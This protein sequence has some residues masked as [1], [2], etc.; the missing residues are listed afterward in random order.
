MGPDLRSS[1]ARCGR[2]TVGQWGVLGVALIAG[3]AVALSDPTVATWLDDES[4]LWSDAIN[5]STPIAPNNAMDQTY[6]AEIAISGHPFTITLDDDFVISELLFSS[7][8]A[9]INAGSR[10]LGVLGTSTLG[11]G[12]LRGGPGGAFRFATGVAEHGAGRN[13]FDTTFNGTNIADVGTLEV[14]G[15]S[16]FANARISGVASVQLG[17]N[18]RLE[19]TEIIGLGDSMT[20]VTTAANASLTAI[21][22][23]FS[24]ALVMID[25]T[26]QFNG[27][28]VADIDDTCVGVGR[29]V[30]DLG[31]SIGPTLTGNGEFIVS[32]GA[33]LNIAG[34]AARTMSGVGP[35]TQRVVVEEGGSFVQRDGGAFTL[36]SVD[37][38]N[39]GTVRVAQGLLSTDGVDTPGDRLT[40][41]QWQV[42]ANSELR[43]VGADI[44]ELAA[45]VSLE[46]PAAKFDA[47]NGLERIVTDG[48][49]ALGAQRNF[50]TAG[51]FD[52][53]AG[54]ALSVAE[55]AT[56]NATG[57]LANL[58]NG[59]L[60]GGSFDLGGTLQAAN[61]AGIQRVQTDLTLRGTGKIDNGLGGDAIASMTSIGEIGRVS[62]L[63][64]RD[65]LGLTSLT[66]EGELRVGAG[67][68]TGSREGITPGSTIEVL[69]DYIQAEG[70]RLVIQLGDDSFG[71]VNV[72]GTFFFG[73]AGGP[74]SAGTLVFETVGKVDLGDSFTI[75]TANAFVG[76]FAAIEG[77]DAGGG[78]FYTVA[79][80]P[81]G[82]TVEVVP[83]PGA[84]GLLALAGLAASRRR[85]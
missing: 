45:G 42:A 44:R 64:G 60:S 48:R 24:K 37:L 76:Q 74:G 5:W 50:T 63:D 54:G 31:G 43:L 39:N 2:A 30:L 81:N 47:I 10:S 18:A 19:D 36:Q 32:D 71:A 13:T 62:A 80:G 85:R 15:S 38:T 35:G 78:R 6:R 12:R 21:D 16:L 59:T 11:T 67:G 57:G 82:L 69:G 55:G 52:V 75:L 17:S 41:G 68:S 40:S 56:F 23:S 29:G 1:G 53:Q 34:G 9:T 77:L 46:G 4:G 61:A 49:L 58:A 66:V 3:Q 51:S 70:S 65:I 26:A 83:A 72:D 33:T 28:L 7:T 14:G 84:A 22:Y 8:S 73:A 79:F 25:G 20:V 27:N